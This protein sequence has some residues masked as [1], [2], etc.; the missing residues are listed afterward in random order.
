MP[1]FQYEINDGVAVISWNT[2]TRNMN[3][4]D[5]QSLSDLEIKRADFGN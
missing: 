3:I 2:P 4:M 1:D 5:L